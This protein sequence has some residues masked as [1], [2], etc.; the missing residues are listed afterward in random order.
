[1][2][3][4]IL[5]EVANNGL[6]SIPYVAPTLKVL[7][8][9]ALVYALK[10]YFG[11]AT[12]S[13]ER[14]M[15]SK[16]VMVTQPPSDPFLVD[17]IEDLRTVT[18]NELIHAEQ[19][20]LS[21]LH[22]IRLFATKWVDNAPPRRLDMV[23]LCA[24]TMTPRF[25]RADLTQ[26]NIESNWGINYLANFH[27]LGIL[28]PAIRAQPP[29][30]DVRIIMGTCSSYIGG[31]INALKDTR[32][33]LPP[34]KAYGTSKLALM[35]FA[36][37]YQKHLDTYQR[38][39]K[40]ANNARVILV[41]PGLTRTPGMRRWLSMGSLWGLLFYMLTWPLWW[42]TLKSP[43]MGAQSFLYA[44]ME[45]DLGRGSGGKFIKE[46]RE[47]GFLKNEIRDEQVAKTLWEFSDKQIE[48]LEKEGAARR[49]REKTDGK[50]DEEKRASED[51]KRKVEPKAPKSNGA[52]AAGSRRSRK[53]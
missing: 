32:S 29:D 4:P 14:L 47:R 22:S 53:A 40:Q 2:P 23:V 35:T 28:S 38:P 39:D 50:G 18:N 45:A 26:D 16:V 3:I 30:R 17:Y 20:D 34:R 8:W 44:A 13:S 31:E 49:A 10:W 41:D 11:G 15:K 1:M 51:A 21:S 19:V 25:G 48:A 9:L 6:S 7:P 36:Q 52:K 5:T 12:T 46:C 37:A 27:L 43:L 24:N 33:P 42:L